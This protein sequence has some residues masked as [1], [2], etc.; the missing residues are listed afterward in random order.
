LSGRKARTRS[1]PTAAI[2]LA[3]NYRYPRALKQRQ[4]AILAYFVKR[5]FAHHQFT[6]GT[7]LIKEF[8]THSTVNPARLTFAEG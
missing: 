8:G 2:E 6:S 4:A 7:E 5:C 1:P 3:R